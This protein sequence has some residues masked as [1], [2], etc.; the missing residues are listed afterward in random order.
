MK[1]VILKFFAILFIKSPISNAS[2]IPVSS[3]Y[4]IIKSVISKY[5]STFV[6]F[7][8]S[9][10]NQGASVNLFSVGATKQYQHMYPDLD[11]RL[12]NNAVSYSDVT[13]FRTT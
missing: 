4:N 2:E 8:Y 1:N 7:L 10:T 3:R 12:F 6:N 9:T 11:H 5:H 13:N